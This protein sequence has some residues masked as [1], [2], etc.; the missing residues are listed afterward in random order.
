MKKLIISAVILL[1]CLVAGCNLVSLTLVENGHEAVKV[2]L[3]GSSR[4]VDNM[5]YVSGWVWYMPLTTKIVEYSV[6]TETVDYAPFTVRTKDGAMFTIDPTLLLEVKPQ[7]TGQV[8][9]KY[10]R[11]LEEVL[12]GPIAAVVK[13]TYKSATST[14]KADS[15]MTNQVAFDKQVQTA[16]FSALEEQGFHGDNL[17]SG[18]T[19]PPALQRTID[20]KNEAIQHALRIDNEVKSAEAEARVKVAQSEGYAKSVRI[21]ADAEAY[22][23]S[24]K[25]TSLTP[26][27]VQQ[28]WIAKWNGALPTTQT[29]SGTTMMMQLPK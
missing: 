9:A 7:H 17:T 27:L 21:E 6:R 13:D 15:L 4:G 26:L 11:T 16:L 5:S 14:Y 1:T 25:Q 18:I 24:K 3:T 12:T 22:A 10:G 2:N 29:G 19:P 20:A 8:Y 28:E 23:N